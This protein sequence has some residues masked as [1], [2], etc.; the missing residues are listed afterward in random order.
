MNNSIA[1][2]LWSNDPFDKRDKKYVDSTSY[3]RLAERAEKELLFGGLKNHQA[4]E[5]LRQKTL[6]SPL[7]SRWIENGNS[8]EK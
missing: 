2:E 7:T 3:L 5:E 1:K 6:P 8:H 4:R